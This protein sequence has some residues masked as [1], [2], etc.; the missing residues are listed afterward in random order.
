MTCTWWDDAIPRHD[1]T[2]DQ[3]PS[4]QGDQIW[5]QNGTKPG[6]FHIRF[7]KKVPELSHLGPIRSTLSKCNEISTEKV[8]NFSQ[9]RSNLSHF[10]AKPD[11]PVGLTTGHTQ[12]G[13][14]GLAPKWVRLALNGT[15]PLGRQMHWNLIWK[16]P[17]IVPFGANLTH[18]G[19]KPTIPSVGM[20]V[21]ME[22]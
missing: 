11:S 18:F 10:E 5:E 22:I 14:V 2:V 3:T 1:F 6:L 7:Q 19:A 17:G 9:I 12:P 4:R 16:S 8:P 20:I 15:N 13:M 21:V